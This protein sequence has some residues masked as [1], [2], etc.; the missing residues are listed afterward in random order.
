[1]EMAAGSL[2]TRSTRMENGCALGGCQ[3][4]KF[5]FLKSRGRHCRD[6][7]PGRNP[8][9]R[10]I[11]RLTKVAVGEI[12]FELQLEQLRRQLIESSLGVGAGWRLHSRLNKI[13]QACGII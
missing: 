12:G 9:R 3:A 4:R 13:E 11:P 8:H 7:L 5:Q 1:M 2:L 10:D 6:F